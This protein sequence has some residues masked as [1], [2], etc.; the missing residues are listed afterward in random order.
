MKRVKTFNKESVYSDIS[1]DKDDATFFKYIAKDKSNIYFRYLGGT[2]D[3]SHFQHEKYGDVIR[4][5]VPNFK[6]EL[7]T[8]EI[9]KLIKEGRI[10]V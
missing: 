6:Y 7:S 1:P 8:D 10:T 5:P 3:Y 2:D 4:F 9:S